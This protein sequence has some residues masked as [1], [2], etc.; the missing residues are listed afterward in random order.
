MK[1]E[2]IAKVLFSKNGNGFRSTK[3]TLPV[4]WV[5]EIGATAEDREVKISIDGKKII[6]EKIENSL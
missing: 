1:E 3:I 2:R 4:P 5:D 6:I